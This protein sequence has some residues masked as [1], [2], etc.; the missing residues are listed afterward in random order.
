MVDFQ[1]LWERTQE[2]LNALLEQSK[3][4]PDIAKDYFRDLSRMEIYGWAGF[5]VGFI[6]F[7]VGF[8]IWL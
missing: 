4:W 2:R 5:G 7:I 3:E 1:E 6:I 8:V